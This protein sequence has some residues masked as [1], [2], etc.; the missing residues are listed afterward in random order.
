MSPSK[1]QQYALIT[2]ASKGIGREFALIAAEQGFVPII[3]A[4]SKTKLEELKAEIADTYQVDSV[5]LVSD[6]SQPGSCEQLYSQVIDIC[7]TPHIVINNAGFGIHGPFLE[8]DYTSIQKMIQLN[9]ASL[10][11]LTYLFAKKMQAQL[12]NER[13]YILNVASTAAF[14]PGPYMAA[15]FATKAFVLNFSQGLA[16][17]LRES[18]TSITTLCPGPTKTEFFSQPDM[19]TASF[20]EK[21]VNMTAREVAE[22]GFQAMLETRPVVVAGAINRASVQVQRLIPRQWVTRLLGS[23]LQ[24]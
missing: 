2:G 22:I 17:E 8:Q 15:Y 1:P 23:V 11:E 24:N 7:N 12:T 21:T 4:R 20:T 9:V 10:T 3:T 19:T 18:T 6:L 16:H 14:S 5:I 13:T